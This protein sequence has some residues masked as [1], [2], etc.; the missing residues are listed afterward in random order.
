MKTDKKIVLMSR[1]ETRRF[2]KISFPTLRKFTSSGI[3]IA[4]AL[5]GKIYYKKHEIIEALK[6]LN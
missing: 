3:L 5:G 2:L 6:P 4:Y 1:E